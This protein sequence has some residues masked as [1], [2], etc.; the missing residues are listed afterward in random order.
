VDHLNDL[1]RQPAASTSSGRRAATL[2]GGGDTA[3]FE[4]ISLGDLIYDRVTIDPQALEAFDFLHPAN[5]SDIHEL[6]VWSQ[7]IV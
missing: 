2:L 1:L 3:A 7:H 5:L 6:A 4:A